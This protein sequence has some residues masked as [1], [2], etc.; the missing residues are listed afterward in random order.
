MCCH[1][2]NREKIATR[3]FGVAII[4][5][6]GKT[7]MG[8]TEYVITLTGKDSHKVMLPV[9]QGSF[10]IGTKGISKGE[11]D[12]WVEQDCAI[13]WNAFN[14]FYTGYGR[15][16]KERY[17]YGN[18]PRWFYYSGNDTGFIEWSSKRSIEEF[19][20]ASHVDRT[21]DFTDADIERLSIR[22]EKCK[23]QV[24]TGEKILVLTL[25]GILENFDIKKCDKIPC[26][27][28]CPDYPKEK[29]C[30]QLPVFPI[31]EQAS[32][33]SIY[34]LPTKAAFDCASLLQFE[35][36]KDIT[37]HGNMT[38]LSA[39]TKLRQLEGIALRYVPDLHD[40]PK[41]ESW[42]RLKSF[43]GYNIEESAGKAFIIE[44]KSL[45]KERQMD[46]VSVTKLRNQI[47]FATEYGIPFSE[48]EEKNAKKATRA[49]K[50]CFNKIK[51][52][53][54]EDEI[55]HT[56]REFIEKIN[57]LDGIETTERED[58]FTAILQLKEE[59]KIDISPEKWELWFDETREF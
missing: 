59:A 44:L 18:W 45:K 57:R 25:S 6:E 7:A 34:N 55:Y 11:Y 35:N 22:T 28:F 36:L 53:D 21:V 5:K 41:L 39:L 1:K 38:N 33:L 58:V 48:W 50:S 23:I 52:S 43:I 15:E 9:G 32:F 24:L 49:Y 27:A 17:P 26:L 51:Q 47:W 13:N 8:N 20:W 42:K 30:C 3:E 29:G 2:S 54:T 4:I 10:S 31:L 40:M 12:V 16:H 37:L 19:H 56:I 46:F 14:E